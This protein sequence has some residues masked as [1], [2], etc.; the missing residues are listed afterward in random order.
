MDSDQAVTGLMA[1]HILGGEFPFFFYAQDYCGSIEA[2]LV[3]TVFLFFGATRFTLNLT[4][5]LESLFFILFIYYLARFIFD[6]ETALLSALFSALASY[7]LIFHS[8]LARAAYIEIPIIGVL[9]FIVAFKI[10]YRQE[11]DNRNI[12][13]LGFF[14]GLGIW[15]HF[16]IVFYLPPIFLFW[17]IKDRWFWR[18]RAFLFFLLGLILGGLPL[19]VHNI[20]HP[21]VT[22][23]YLLGTAGGDEP[24]L[25]SLKD[26]FL[27]SVSGS[28][29]GKKQRHREILSFPIS[30]FSCI[31]FTWVCFYSFSCPGE[32]ASSG[33]FKFKIGSK[34][35][36]GSFAPFSL[37]FSGYFFPER[38]CLGPYQ[39]LPPAHICRSSDLVCRLDQKD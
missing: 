34:Q 15:T 2:Y 26:F 13:I 5:C 12:F 22:W 27:Y 9:L 18:R 20:A 6:K 4:I 25:T 17:F 35:R 16:L 1:R 37:S 33:L 14:C 24:A 7:Y 3:S 30:L 39:S 11:G 36:P 28:P 21:L 38:I 32:K 8:V 29:G 31:S 23:H 10:I 19:W